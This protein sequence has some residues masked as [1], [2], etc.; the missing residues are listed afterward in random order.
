[1]CALKNQKILQNVIDLWLVLPAPQP[2]ELP[3]AAQVSMAASKCQWSQMQHDA[4]SVE[5]RT[6]RYND[7]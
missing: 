3:A 4:D 7:T 6:F 1:M 5:W 2:E